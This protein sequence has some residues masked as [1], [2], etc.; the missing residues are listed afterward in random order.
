[1]QRRFVE[2]D[3]NNVTTVTQRNLNG[4]LDLGFEF[5]LSKQ[6]NKVFNFMLSTNVYHSKMDA[7]N[8]TSDYNESTFGMRSSFNLGWKKNGHK[9]QASGWV[10]PGANVGQGRMKTMF[11]TDLAYSR[12][13]FSEKGKL[14]FRVSDVFN[15]RRFGIDTYG[16]NFDQ[17]FVYNRLSRFFTINISYNFGDQEN[18]RQQRRANYGGSDGG[19]M[20]GGF[21]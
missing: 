3:S 15:T 8:L 10:M 17:S 21:F 18:N 16:R 7:S 6:V 20:D 1:M 19:G 2:V 12:P 9:I 11:S 4:S 14:T 5:M 13:V